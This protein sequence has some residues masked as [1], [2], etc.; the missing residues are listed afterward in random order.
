[1]QITFY[2]ELFFSIIICISI[3]FSKWEIPIF[4]KLG[5]HIITFF[6]RGNHHLNLSGSISHGVCIVHFTSIVHKI[7]SH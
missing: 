5:K 7:I 2:V 6:S 3:Y 1:M 4:E